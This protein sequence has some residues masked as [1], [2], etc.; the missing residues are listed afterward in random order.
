MNENRLKMPI[1]LVSFDLDN[2]LWDT[3]DVLVDAQNAMIQWINPRVTRYSELSQVDHRRIYGDVVKTNP[4]ILHDV[5]EL[6][7]RVLRQTF[8]TCG[9]AKSESNEL[10][11]GAFAVFYAW[12]QRVKPFPEA[13][14][15]LTKLIS[16][17]WLATVTNGNADVEVTPIASFFRYNVTAASV[18]VMKPAREPFLKVL[19]MAGVIPSEAVHIGDNLV[20]D[21][22][23]ARGAGMHAIWVN[24]AQRSAGN[25]DVPTVYSLKEVEAAITGIEKNLGLD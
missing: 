21:I 11:R 17:Y 13:I 1:K 25:T 5:S 24:F 18:G 3:Y 6:R 9:C 19:E 8:E 12:R 4:D 20:D 16:K 2:T 23:G 10:A 14:S 7:I 22:Q 15:L